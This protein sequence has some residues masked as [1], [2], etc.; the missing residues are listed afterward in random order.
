MRQEGEMHTPLPDRDRDSVASTI[1]TRREWGTL[2]CH[3]AGRKGWGIRYVG[4][5]HAVAGPTCP[6]CTDGT[7]ALGRRDVAA[8]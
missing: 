8:P 7:Y 5:A 4:G 3:A 1:V 6:F 2:Q